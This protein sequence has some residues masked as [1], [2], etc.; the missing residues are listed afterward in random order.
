MHCLKNTINHEKLTHENPHLLFA[1]QTGKQARDGQTH[2]D[3]EKSKK[4]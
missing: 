1:K 2:V 4:L 3:P